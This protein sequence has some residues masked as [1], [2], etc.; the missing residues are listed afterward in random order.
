M[1]RSFYKYI[2]IYIYRERKRE[3]FLIFFLFY[4]VFSSRFK[5]FSPLDWQLLY[6]SFDA[7]SS[8]LKDEVAN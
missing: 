6:Q 8:L 3:I 7:W 4:C 1:K 2:Y 5:R